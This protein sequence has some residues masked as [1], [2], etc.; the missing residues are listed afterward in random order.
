KISFLHIFLCDLC[1]EALRQFTNPLRYTDLERSRR[2]DIDQ[3][4]EIR[5]GLNPFTVGNGVADT[6]S[7]DAEGL[8][9]TGHGD[10]ALPHTGKRGR[11]DMPAL[12][13]EIFINF[14]GKDEQIMLLCEGRYPIEFLPG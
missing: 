3:V 1:I 10:G 8:G 14:I 2:T 12:I 5:H 11:T 6:P 4:I 13:D 9:I 7:S